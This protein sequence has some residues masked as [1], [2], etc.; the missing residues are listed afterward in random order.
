VTATST[1]SRCGAQP[2]PDLAPGLIASLRYKID[3]NNTLRIGYT[4]DRGRHHQTGELGYL[5]INGFAAAYFPVDNP[6][7]DASGNIIEKRNRMSYAILHQA[8][9]EYAG[10]FFD[11]RLS[12]N[13]G[14]RAPFLR[15]DLTNN[16]FTTSASGFVDC[17]AN[18]SMN[19]AYAAAHPPMPCRSSASSTTT[20]CCRTQASPST[21]RR[22]SRCLPTIRRAAGSG[23]GQPVQRLLL[24][25]ERPQASRA[26]T[27]DNY[28]V[29]V[30][31][32][33]GKIWRRF[34][35]VHAVPEPSG[36]GL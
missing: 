22:A 8:S 27:T 21:S 26:E 18:N 12:L 20:A 14:V 16:C 23:Y 19:A 15:R 5:A 33:S 3:D 31:Y 28:D 34:G 13:V 9:G 10:R 25:G 35:L 7:T 4:Y 1:R 2:H 29:G 24:F 11:N 32:R 6:I 36:L 30:R 17:L